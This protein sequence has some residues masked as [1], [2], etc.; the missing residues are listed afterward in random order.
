[1]SPQSVGLALLRRI[2]RRL[3]STYGPQ[4]WWPGETDFEV[5]V[6]A[7]LTQNTAWSNVEKAIG[8][9]S[10][11]GRL[12]WS[13]LAETPQEEL[14]RLIRPAGYFRVK[15][16][17]L[18]NFLEWMGR[19]CAGDLS[20]LRGRPWAEVRDSL[21]EVNGIGPETADSILLYALDQPSFV[22]DAYT[23]R[24]FSRHGWVDGE[25]RYGDL[26]AL[27][28]DRLPADAAMY[29]EY[30]GLLVKLAKEHCR[31]RP[32]CDGCPLDGLWGA[33]PAQRP[34]TPTRTVRRADGLASPG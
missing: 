2:Y 29:N 27:F 3:H 32:S 12:T 10:R 28:Q 8:N 16:R 9:L 18:R 20:R 31:A 30:H 24:I 19:E 17:R 34:T 1:M 5:A 13:A 26:R 11:A 22:V 21:L 14:E 25:I 7:I 33:S 23:R 15:A 4:D 6:G